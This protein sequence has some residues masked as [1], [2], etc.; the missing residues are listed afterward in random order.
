ML[1]VKQGAISAFHINAQGLAPSIITG[2]ALVSYSTSDQYLMST[3]FTAGG[4]VGIGPSLVAGAALHTTAQLHVEGLAVADSFAY[5]APVVRT[6]ILAPEHFRLRGSHY[7]QNIELADDGSLFMSY[8][9]S[10]VTVSA[11][12]ALPAD[13]RIAQVSCQRLLTSGSAAGSKLRIVELNSLNTLTRTVIAEFDM[14]VPLPSNQLQ[15]WS[16]GP[17][18][19]D[20]SRPNA[21]QA[22]TRFIVELEWHADQPGPHAKLAHCAVE[23]TS[24]SL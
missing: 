12:L 17:V 2:N 18:N 14:G 6:A 11:P 8:G 21:P 23:Y 5:A 20:L 22:T 13:A 24:T 10:D 3:R 15:G 9:W 1:E 19:I 7:D 4:Q 16:S